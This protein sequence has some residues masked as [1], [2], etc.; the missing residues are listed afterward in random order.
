MLFALH[1][2]PLGSSV[3]APKVHLSPT[4]TPPCTDVCPES[5]AVADDD[6][7]EFHASMGHDVWEEAALLPHVGRRADAHNVETDAEVRRGHPCLAAANGHAQQ[8]VEPWPREGVVEHH[9]H[10]LQ[11][12]RV[13]KQSVHDPSP[14]EE[15][16]IPTD[17][18]WG[19]PF[20]SKGVK[21]L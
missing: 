17:D 8:S 19:R 2:N 5:H 16:G 3:L 12:Q 6:G 14:Q 10:E 4:V 20:A 18:T 11:V 9:E 21:R 1:V 7:A 15:E 13:Q